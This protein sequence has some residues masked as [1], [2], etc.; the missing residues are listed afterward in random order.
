MEWV[1]LLIL[2]RIV[3]IHYCMYI[4]LLNTDNH[5]VYKMGES[6]GERARCRRRRAQRAR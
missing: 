4:L 1:G 6:G 5:I 3:L 2:G